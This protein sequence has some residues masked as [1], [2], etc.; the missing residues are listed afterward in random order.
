MI[1]PCGVP[2]GPAS[3]RRLEK[4]RLD[5]Q[6]IEIKNISIIS[7]KMMDKRNLL[8]LKKKKKREFFS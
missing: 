6:K 2:Y 3:R 1:C 5:T 7:D 4:I 8:R